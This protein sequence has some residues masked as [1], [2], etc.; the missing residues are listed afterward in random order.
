MAVSTKIIRRRIRSIGNTK[1]ITK[2]MEM[3]AAVKM[4]KAVNAVLASRAYAEVAWQTVMQLVARVDRNEHPL[5]QPHDQTTAAAFILVT[6]NRG[7]CGGFN[8]RM[9]AEASSYSQARRASGVTDQSWM[10][11]GRKGGE[12]LARQQQRVVAEFEKQD[13]AMSS[14]DVTALATM[15]VK[16]YLAG[17]Y[18]LVAVMYTDFVT[19]LR[20]QPRVKQL[21]PLEPTPDEALG[22]VGS[23]PSALATATRA[24][25]ASP[26]RFRSEAS[27]YLFEPSPAEV[28]D[29]FLPR[30]VE[31]Q[32]YQ[33][34]LESTASEHSA[35][36]L[37]MR[38]ASD[39]ATD[40]M[41]GLTLIYNQAR[42]AGIT[43]E[44][45]EISGGK[46]ALE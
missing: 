45:A 39:A 8:S 25:D 44:I 42:Q 30:L 2:A 4:R 36:M 33:A 38:N 31:I 29:Q 46:A 17:Q 26:L 35:R 22:S 37:A 1:K 24:G 12:A 20:Q 9:V 14:A 43:R 5:L 21:L 28:L 3:V 6:S 10:T 40:M 13:T 7:L 16:G 19:P 27:E 32:L 41:D 15:V 18:D 34:L 11:M 23:R